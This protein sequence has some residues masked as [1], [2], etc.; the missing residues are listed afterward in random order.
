MRKMKKYIILISLGLLITGCK[1]EIINGTGNI[2]Y[3]ELST[4]PKFKEVVKLDS[5]S[6]LLKNKKNINQNSDYYQIKIGDKGGE[7]L[8][9]ISFANG[10]NTKSSAGTTSKSFPDVAKLDVYLAELSS[11]PVSGT[12]DPL[13]AGN[14]IGSQNNISGSGAT[15]DF[16][17]LFSNV[18][19]NSGAKKYFVGVVAK[20]S[21]G[22]AIAK[23]PSPAW[24]G[25][26]VSLAPTVY[27]TLT[28]VSVN[29]S[30]QVSSTNDLSVFIPL[31]DIAGATADADVRINNG[32]P[33]PSVITATSP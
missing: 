30:F 9:K 12:D 2:K 19:A 26:T 25:T 5:N 15:S 3:S 10:F 22:N 14:I 24:T 29:S 33:V 27:F 18:P 16:N 11:A 21:S 23:T 4:I 32:L 1:S 8:T 7:F 31:T 17:L 28:G 20:D 6:E 13:V